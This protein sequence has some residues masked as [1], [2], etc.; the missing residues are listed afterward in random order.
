M[1]VIELAQPVSD[2]L[3]FVPLIPPLVSSSVNLLPLYIMY[4]GSISPMALP[5]AIT[6]VVADLLAVIQTGSCLAFPNT[7]GGVWSR[8]KPVSST[9]QMP[10]RLFSNPAEFNTFSRFS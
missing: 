8:V 9:F 2:V 5:A 1:N 10:V 3:Y 4:G 6:V 7:L